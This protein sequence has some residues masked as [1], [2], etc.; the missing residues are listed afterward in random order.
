MPSSD[1]IEEKQINRPKTYQRVYRGF[2]CFCFSCKK[3][4]V[5][6]IAIVFCCK[7]EY[8][9]WFEDVLLCLQSAT[10]ILWERTLM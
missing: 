3:T 1:M 6:Y 5:Y 7:S 2:F 4:Q 8:S 9:E 10:L